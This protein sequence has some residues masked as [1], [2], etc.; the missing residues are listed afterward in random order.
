MKPR[1]YDVGL[2]TH[3][4]RVLEWGP[5]SG[6][7]A[8]A[9]HG[10]PDCAWAWRRVAPLL[11]AAGYRVAAPFLRGYAP[12][13][14]PVDRDYSVRALA[15]D[16][17][18]LH[19]RLGG[20]GRTPLIGHDWGAIITT[21]LAGRTTAA[22]E[23]ASPYGRHIAL[24]VPPLALM[25]PSRDT[26]RPW[27]GAVGRQPFRSWY[28]G[29]NQVPGLSES[30]FEWLVRRLW[31]LW[32]PGYDASEDLRYL[33]K[34]VPDRAHAEAV[35]SYYRVLRDPRARRVPMRPPAA[36]LLYLH[37]DRDGAL[38]PG[39]FPVVAAR[40]P[41]AALVPGAGHFLHLE[42]PDTVAGHILGFL[43]SLSER[44]VVNSAPHPG[45][46]PVRTRSTEPCTDSREWPRLVTS[47]MPSGRN[48]SSIPCSAGP[49]HPAD[50]SSTY[51]CVALQ[52]W[53]AAETGSSPV[54]VPDSI[55]RVTWRTRCP[56]ATRPSGNR[57]DDSRSFMSR[58]GNRIPPGAVTPNITRYS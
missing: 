47:L 34:A 32:S 52:I 49:K 22:A 35:V 36:P 37:G 21:T 38:D 45:S 25:N 40:L 43:Q 56:K 26:L 58:P 11:A 53:D 24:A 13:G 33:A 42:Q 5:E 27:L 57:S 29:F 28:I 20:D 14:I 9:L 50:S 10:F 31:R 23:A 16:A 7:L 18:T 17:V 39:F 55:T 12:S 2:P 48:T 54:P 46:F 8:V 30:Y 4:V 15:A 41:D 3:T 44:P 6:P 1:E 51:P 19:D